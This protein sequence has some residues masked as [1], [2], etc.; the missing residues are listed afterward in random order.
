MRKQV[1]A[2]ALVGTLALV[3]CSSSSV[4]LDR[5]VEIEGLT[6]SVPSGWI[7]DGDD[8]ELDIIQS[9]YGTRTFEKP[10]SDSN[11]MDAIMVSYSTTSDNSE[12][13]DDFMN[14]FYSDSEYK[15]V[16]E[17]VIDGSE[18][19]VYDVDMDGS[20]ISQSIAFIT[21]REMEYTIYLYGDDVSIDSLLETVSI[22]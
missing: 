3:G 20:N 15:M 19:S 13:P 22:S 6:I 21:G 11:D 17:S 9:R 4:S 10:G 8:H 18:C 12:S 14:E 2:A 5:E 16:S 1:I 7:E